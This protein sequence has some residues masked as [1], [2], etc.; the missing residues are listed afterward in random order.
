MLFS[1]DRTPSRSRVFLQPR[2]MASSLMLFREPAKGIGRLQSGLSLKKM[3]FDKMSLPPKE[4]ESW[5]P[6]SRKGLAICTDGVG[7]GIGDLHGRGRRAGCLDDQT[8]SSGVGLSLWIQGSR[9]ICDCVHLRWKLRHGLS[10]LR[11]LGQR[12]LSMV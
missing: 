4:S 10:P 1:R 8:F 7:E 11:M 6:C 12:Q 3:C 2:P 5:M 9:C